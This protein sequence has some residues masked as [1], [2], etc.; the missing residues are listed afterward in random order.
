MDTDSGEP[1]GRPR[2]TSQTKKKETKKNS[3]F[4]FKWAGRI[5]LISLITSF[6]L[7]YSS[8]SILEGVNYIMATVM[9]LIVI[10][11]GI[12]FDIMGT[13]VT[14]AS[15]KVLNSMASRKLKGAK[16]ALYFVS[17]AASVSNFCN[18]V[19]G[20]ICGIISG[21]MC[22]LIASGIAS[23][24]GRSDITLITVAATSVT[25]ALTI[26]GKALGKNIAIKYNNNIIYTVSR[27]CSVFV[28]DKKQ[29]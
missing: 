22:V 12:L 8:E 6:I 10:L 23:D 14:T 29:S 20:D 13:A 5:A 24:L 16:L 15:E 19:I 25:S 3:L 28:R 9:L 18:D 21:S 11:F 27:V 1:G 7:S 4:D 2:Q 17:H 26:G